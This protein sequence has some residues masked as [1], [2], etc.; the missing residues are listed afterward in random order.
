MS[1]YLLGAYL[2]YRPYLT[3]TGASTLTS[4]TDGL[5]RKGCKT[6]RVVMSSVT[7]LSRQC[8][9]I[10]SKSRSVLKKTRLLSGSLLAAESMDVY[11]RLDVIDKN[12]AGVLRTESPCS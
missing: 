3:R 12:D 5:F 9:V 10:C 6:A 2:V 8:L 4:K 7:K 1:Y 11:V